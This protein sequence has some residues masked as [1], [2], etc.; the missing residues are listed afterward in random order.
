[1]LTPQ[2]WRGDN[3]LKLPAD[4]H[5]TS[6]G[7]MPVPGFFEMWLRGK[8][9]ALMGPRAEELWQASIRQE[10]SSCSKGLSQRT[11]GQSETEHA[12]DFVPSRFSLDDVTCAESKAT[13]VAHEAAQHVHVANTRIQWQLLGTV[14][15]GRSPVAKSHLAMERTLA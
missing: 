10:S 6:A 12:T 14:L 5:K 7:I 11:T 9:A 3:A 13:P 8:A 15:L 2:S 4:S 1:M